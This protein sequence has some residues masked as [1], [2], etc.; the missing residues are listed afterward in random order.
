MVQLAMRQLITAFG[1][2]IA[3]L[4]GVIGVGAHQQEGSCPMSSLPDCCKKAQSASRTAEV[5]MARLCCNLNCSESGSTGSSTSSNFSPQSI[6]V[7]ACA[8]M[9]L[10]VVDCVATVKHVSPS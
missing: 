7:P 8:V 2:C 6:D 5:S 3:L 9:P 1:L 4:G 10:N